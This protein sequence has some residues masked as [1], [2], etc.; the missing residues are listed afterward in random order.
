MNTCPTPDTG[1]H[2]AA[3]PVVVQIEDITRPAHFR[4]LPDALAALWESL[5]TLPMT[6]AQAG[7]FE[8]FLTRP[9]SAERVR[10]FLERDGELVLTLR[11]DG[12]LHAVL[13][14]PARE[15]PPGGRPPT[16]AGRAR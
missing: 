11:L 1:H 2:A 8:Y 15:E 10:A 4:R 14:H 9:N 16:P 13:I 12:R 7:A 6:E 3:G 5:R